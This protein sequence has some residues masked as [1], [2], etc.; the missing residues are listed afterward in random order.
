MKSQIEQLK[1]KEKQEEE[2]NKE[3]KDSSVPG[4]EQGSLVGTYIDVRA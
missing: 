2:E 4:Q 1:K 3:E